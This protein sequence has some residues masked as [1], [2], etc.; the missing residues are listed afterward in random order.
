[1]KKNQTMEQEFSNLV[2]LLQHRAKFQA[3]KTAYIFLV[4]GETQEVQLTYGELDRQARAILIRPSTY[5]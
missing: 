2:E 1:M 4:D 3:D 5:A